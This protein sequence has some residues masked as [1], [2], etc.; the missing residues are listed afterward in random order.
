MNLLATDKSRYFAQ[1]SPIIV[2]FCVALK[3]K[4]KL[5]PNS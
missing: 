4:I 3:I 1:P 5:N 2:Y